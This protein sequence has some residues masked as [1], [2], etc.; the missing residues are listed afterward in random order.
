MAGFRSFW[1]DRIVHPAE[2]GLTWMLYGA[3]GLM[4]LDMASWAGGALGRAIGPRLRVTQTA[5]RSLKRVFPDLGESEIDRIVM[6]MWDNLGRTAGEHPHLAAFDP[7]ARNSRVEV[8]G[9]EYIDALRD[10]GKTGLLFAGHIANWEI[11][12]LAGVKRGLTVHL[13][14]RRANNPLFDAIVQKGRAVLGGDLYPKGSD[15]A[16]QVL[17]AMIRGDHMAMLVDQKMNDGI[18]VPFLGRDA[19]TASAIAELAVRFDCPVVPARVE[20]LKGARFRV[21]FE[22]PLVK[23]STGDR[24]ADVKVLMT[25]I[26]DRLSDW[27]RARPEQWLWVHNRWPAE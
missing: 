8:V 25:M 14:Y 19:M 10:D 11:S 5:R 4:P 15:G 9:G 22:P 18:A 3:F 12:P 26:N 21:T 16:K 13:V 6:E 23:P 7:Y 1:I 20:R 24:K 17:R 27:I 2:A